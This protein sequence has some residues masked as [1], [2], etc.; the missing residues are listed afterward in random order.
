MKIRSLIILQ[1][2]LYSSIF[3]VF[4]KTIYVSPKGN[5]SN[6]G[7]QAKP[8]LTF[9]KAQELARKLPVNKNVEVVFAAGIYYLPQT[10]VLTHRDTKAKGCTVTYRSETEGAAVLSGGK[11]L[12]LTW[13]PYKNGI[14]VASLPEDIVV[15]QLFINGERQRMARYPNAIPGRIIF[16]TWEAKPRIKTDSLNDPLRPERI[17]NWKNP[18]GGYIHAMHIYLWG[19]M[20]YLIKG[21]NADGKL[22]TEGGWQNNRPSEMHGAYRF[23]E[24]IFEELDAPGEWYYNKVQR[25]IYYMPQAGTDMKTAKVEVV[26]LKHLIEFS[27]S[28]ANPVQS[29]RL[30]GF[31]FRQAA[32][33]FMENKEPLLR[34][35]W[36]IY[37]G[38]AVLFNGAENCTVENCE[39]DQLGGNA[40]FVNK[41]NKR[42][43]VCGCYIHNCGA[44]GVAF[45]GDTSAV[46]SPQTFVNKIGFDK[47]DHT[48]GTRSDNYPQDCL[49]ENCLIAQIGRDEKQTAGVQVSMSY[50]IRIN[51]CSIYDVPRAGI[52]FGEGTFGGHVIENCDIF[53]TVLETGDHGSFNSWGRDR[54]WAGEA[55]LTVDEVAKYPDMP[56]WDML[57]PNIIR[58]NRWRCDHGWDVDLDDGSSN[59]QIYNNLMLNRG[60]KLREGYNRTVT[61]NIIIG[62]SIHPHCWYPNSNDV[63][64]NNIIF[65]PYMPALMEKCIAPGGKWGKEIDKN[66]FVCD[67]KGMVRFAANGCDKNSVFADPQFVNVK[68]GDFRVKEGSPAFKIGFV[69]F[70]MDQFGVQKPSLKRIAKTP[71]LPEVVINISATTATIEK[72]GTTWM[73]VLLREPTGDEM[74][75]FGVGFDDGGVLFTLVAENSLAAKSG[76][77]TGDLL[78][79]VNGVKIRTIQQLKNYISTKNIGAKKHVFTVVRNQSSVKITINQPL[80]LILN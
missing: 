25:K 24:N 14:Y 20:H 41:Y 45:V 12:N 9:G 2:A 43:A 34:S 54:L 80:A 69:N 79:S 66:L 64:K 42:I 23:V 28:K 53:N 57:A 62:S 13:K 40:I 19:G 55:K 7:T 5:D 46:R 76:F 33:T 59:Y 51:H 78:Q 4:G 61:N 48:P 37:R 75:A 72:D 27:G 49:V 52:N 1:L 74:S 63:I 31:V 58:N 60:L 68:S 18:E 21:K 26:R 38:G 70:P 77:R 32:R 71:E 30:K 3:P 10:V 15:D 47:M 39:F 8:V 6:S 35:D 16:D 56:T 44:S 67:A 17:A 22:K 50:K 73:D 11:Q 29:V 65:R 36:T